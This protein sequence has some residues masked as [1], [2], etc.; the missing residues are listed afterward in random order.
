MWL[1]CCSAASLPIP[2]EEKLITFSAV[3]KMTVDSSLT[4][5]VI[6]ALVTEPSGLV[7]L[8]TPSG[9]SILD[10]YDIQHFTQQLSAERGFPISNPTSLLVDKQNSLWVGSWTQGLGRIEANRKKIRYF[11]PDTLRDGVE[12][13]KIQTLFESKGGDI[14][15][16]THDQGLIHFDPTTDTF[17]SFKP[18]KSGATLLYDDIRQILQ[19]ENGYLWLAT[20]AGISRFD[21]VKQVFTTDMLSN[22]LSFSEKLILSIKLSGDSLWLGSASGFMEYNIDS[23][24]LTK[25]E[26]TGYV[27]TSVNEIVVTPN[28]GLWLGTFNG[29]MH[30]DTQSR[31]FSR[32]AD[33]E[34][35][36]ATGTEIATLLNLQP[37]TL[38]LATSR[39]GL[40]V[41]NTADSAIQRVASNNSDYTLSHPIWHM[42]EDMQGNIWLGTNAGMLLYDPVL[43]DYK[44]LPEAILRTI[45]SRVTSVANSHNGNRIWLATNNDIYAYDLET[46]TLL[47]QKQYLDN[48]GFIRIKKIFTD[49]N[50]NTWISTLSNGVFKLTENGKVTQ[51]SSTSGTPSLVIP[52][53]AIIDMLEDESGRIWM[54]SRNGQLLVREPGEH[55]TTEFSVFDYVMNEKAF[56]FEEVATGFKQGHNRQL[57]IGTFTGL[58]IVDLVTQNARK[59]TVEQGLAS[60]EIRS[61]I[62]DHAGN[63]WLATSIGITQY[64]PETNNTKHFSSQDGLVSTT[65]NI[66]STL[67]GSDGTLYFGTEKGLHKVNAVTSIELHSQ[68]PLHITE[69]WVNNQKL[70]NIQ[71]ALKDN[72]LVLN[73]DE[74]NLV[75]KYAMYDHRPNAKNELYYLLSGFDKKWQRGNVSRTATYTNLESG[76]YTFGVRVAGSNSNTSQA[77]INIRIAPSVFENV[78]IRLAIV[79]FAVIFSYAIYKIRVAHLEKN[80]ERLNKLIKSRTQNMLVLSNIGQEITRSLSFDEILK[81]VQRHLNQIFHNNLILLGTFNDSSNFIEF[82][83]ISAADKPLEFTISLDNVQ[84]PVVRSLKHNATVSVDNISEVQ[85]FFDGAAHLFNKQSH[86]T[87]IIQPLF[88]ETKKLGC[89]CVLSKAPSAYSHYDQQF[90]RTISAYTAIALDNAIVSDQQRQTQQQRIDW[91][92]NVNSYLRHEMKN[93]MLGAKTSIAM[94]RRKLTDHDLSKYLNRA[95]QSHDEM[96]H[97]LNAVADTTSLE[98]AI[99]RAQ[100]HFIDLSKTLRERHEYFALLYPEI[101]IR[102][103]IAPDIHIFGS[104]ELLVQLVDK[105]VNNAIEHHETGSEVCFSLLIK[106]MQCAIVVQNVGPPLPPIDQNIFDLFVST[107]AASD[108]GNLGMGL[109]IAKLI[110]EFHKGHIDASSIGNENR[111]GAK[112]TVTLPILIE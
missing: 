46:Q 68:A 41:L 86:H 35:T 39:S 109:Y 80:E 64:I 49:K 103:N 60:N 43:D 108:N 5:T 6:S 37:N 81:N 102:A 73:S 58:I 12:L 83:D 22:D 95:D 31:T 76:D 71:S 55:S 111:G 70:D 50:N 99:M 18:S 29:L 54:L 9:L 8:G 56:R 42:T 106:E 112:F 15:I 75:F 38:M 62:T 91:L 59:I 3:G 63:I 25:Y 85:Q 20:A 105:L 107:K 47:P 104:Q 10:G 57:M 51:Y 2:S 32:F 33:G 84:H 28:G 30:F 16:G 101:N 34:Y 87:L 82:R 7:W 36:Y 78:W 53:D 45:K 97:I 4:N 44:Q 27:S 1:F 98:V 72:T 13:R 89:L 17:K 61:V 79:L 26:P 77:A 92:E 74:R 11:D 23:K 21:T 52:S 96:R 40:I 19:D 24:K 14:W 88:K 65:L 48:N 100:K 93:A 67:L 66:G 69:V 110:T 90:L 94:I